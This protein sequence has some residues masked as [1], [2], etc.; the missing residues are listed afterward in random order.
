M[1]KENDMPK[2]VRPTIESDSPFLAHS[3]WAWRWRRAGIAGTTT[4]SARCTRAGIPRE[5]QDWAAAEPGG[6][7][8][9][10]TAARCHRWLTPSCGPGTSRRMV[11]RP[12]VATSRGARPRS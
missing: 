12:P 5:Q 1:F 2:D 8:G 7:S 10:R 6:A 11:S 3:G 9:R 4:P